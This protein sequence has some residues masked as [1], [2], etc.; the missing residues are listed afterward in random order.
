[1][2]S[3]D[4]MKE[5]IKGELQ[6]IV[7]PFLS[8][9]KSENTRTV[10]RQ[11]IEFLVKRWDIHWREKSEGREW[12]GGW[13]RSSEIFTEINNPNPYTVTR[14]LRELTTAGIIERRECSH[15]KGQ[16]GKK[17]VFYRVPGHYNPLHF[18]SRA[19]LLDLIEN[20]N[21][22]LTVFINRYE[23]AQ[24][25]FPLHTGGKELQPLVNDYLKRAEVAKASYFAEMQASILKEPDPCESL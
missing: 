18:G 15:A 23:A 14:L 20:M 19:E 4:R 1:M 3:N 17:P 11:I 12:F 7:T 21:K 9:L 22:T 6:E 25:I 8:K 5:H 13:T 24:A 16:P 10:T 2:K